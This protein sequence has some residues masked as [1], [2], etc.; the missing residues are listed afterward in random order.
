MI[1]LKRLHALYGSAWNNIKA[2]LLEPL[3]FGLIKFWSVQA[4]YDGDAN[5]IKAWLLKCPRNQITTLD[6]HDGIGVVDVADL[7]SQEQIDRTKD[8]IFKRGANANMRY[9]S[10]QYGNLDIYQA[11][12]C[13]GLHCAACSAQYVKRNSS[14]ARLSSTC[15]FL[16]HSLCSDLVNDDSAQYGK[17]DIYRA[18]SALHIELAI[19]FS[20]CAVHANWSPDGDLDNNMA[21]CT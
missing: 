9:N 12:S 4:L 8:N 15:T 2:C 16:V 5:N 20:A 10:A 11:R 6:T 7:M 18:R 21:C 3:H 14:Y 13:L 1:S 17:C 19:C